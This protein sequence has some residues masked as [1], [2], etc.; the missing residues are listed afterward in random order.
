LSINIA[1]Q[2]KEGHYVT[3]QTAKST[4]GYAWT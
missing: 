3:G 4:K 2:E 1:V